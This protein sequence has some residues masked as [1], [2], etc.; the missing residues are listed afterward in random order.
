MTTPQLV[1]PKKTSAILSVS[2][3]FRKSRNSL[4]PTLLE[5]QN[6]IFEVT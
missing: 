5:I 1:T 6:H 2:P 3:E 4:D